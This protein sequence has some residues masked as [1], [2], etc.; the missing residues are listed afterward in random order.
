[1]V[2]MQDVGEVTPG[3]KLAPAERQPRAEPVDEHLRWFVGFPTCHE[4]LDPLWEQNKSRLRVR[5]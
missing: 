3:Q 5:A 1:M 2:R 4:G